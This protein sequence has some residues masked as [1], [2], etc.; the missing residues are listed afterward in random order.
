MAG[1]WR[2]S[3]RYFG[4]GSN[5]ASDYECAHKFLKLMTNT[6]FDVPPRAWRS[7]SWLG[8]HDAYQYFNTPVT[9]E[10][11]MTGIGLAESNMRKI[12]EHLETIK[13]AVPDFIGIPCK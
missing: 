10:Q 12:A 9:E 1:F 5:L 4:K 3:A 11:L 7:F 13:T 8:C 6:H 2:L